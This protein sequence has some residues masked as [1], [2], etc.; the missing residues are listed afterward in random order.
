MLRTFSRV[1][2]VLVAPWVVLVLVA[3]SAAAKGKPAKKIDLIWVHPDFG[4]LGIES[5]ALLPA[6]AYDNNQKN[7]KTV[8]TLF[9]QSVRP[10]GYR[11]V[12]PA[13]AR[14]MIRSGLGGDSTV[15]ALDQALLKHGR[16]DSLVAPRLCRTF[17]TDALLSVRVDLFER[18]EVEWNQSGKPSTTVQIRAAL[19]DSS[20]RLAWSAS[21]G[22]T[23]EGPYHEADRSVAGVK[24]SGATTT[25]L[26]GLSGA[27][28]YEDVLT[29]LFARWIKD[30]PS[31]GAPATSAAPAASSAPSGSAAPALAAP[32]TTR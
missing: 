4:S 25:G 2:A 32:D 17:R 13:V 8:E 24:T 31:R 30:F 20:G 27:P 18:V 22:E 23:G 19:V 16:V 26:T 7:E 15:V 14:E 5:V 21:G 29:R 10:S 6:T 1:A 3:G 11:W 12:T 28:T 9:A